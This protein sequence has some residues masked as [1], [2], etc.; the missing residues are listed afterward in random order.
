MAAPTFDSARAVRF[1]LVRGTVQAG[2]RDERLLLVPA[3]AL[4]TLV[5]A[6]PSEAAETLARWLGT[7]I[8]TRA[9]ERIGDLAGASIDWFVTQL[10]GEAALAG[11][12][13]LSIER[14]GRALVVVIERSPLTPAVLVPLVAGALE[15]AGGRRVWCTALS[16]DDQATRVLVASQQAVER[17]RSWMASGSVWGE[18]LAKLHA[19]AGA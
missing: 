16:H 10:A 18:A 13:A 11:V 2:G 14:W 6:A 8:G 19:G 7:S 3:A 4:S 12:G 5:A 1:D 15:A 9:C 17:V